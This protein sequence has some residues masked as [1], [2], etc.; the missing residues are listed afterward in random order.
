MSIQTQACTVLDQNWRDGY[1]IPSARL[2]PFQWNWDSGFIALGLAYHRPERAIEEIR[3]MFKGQWRHGLL[4]HINFHKPDSNYFPGPSVWSTHVSPFCPAGI[5]TS[6]ITQPPVFAFIVERIAKLPFGRTPAWRDFEREI[7]PQMLAF[8]RYLYTHRDPEQE[9]LVYIQH[10]WEAGTDN[11]PVW[12]DILDAIDVTGMRDISALRRDVKR[13]DA[14][15][16]P[17][18]ANYQRYIYLVDLFIRAQYRDE[19]IA[20]SSPFLVQDVLFNS[21]LV[22]SNFA[23]LELARRL[24]EPTAEIE[25]WNAKAVGAINRKLWDPVT[26]FYYAYDLRNRRSIRIKTSSGFLPLFAGICSEEQ[27]ARL[28]HHLE[29]TFAP[30]P[31]WRICP[32][33]APDEPRFDPVKYW[34]G[35]V[36]FNLNWML[37]H[38]LRRAGYDALA[39]RLM[40]DAMALTEQSGFYEY[41]DARPAG[42]DGTTEGLGADL[43]S[44]NAALLLD[45]THNPA[46]L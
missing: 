21:L 15:H 24:G 9:G 41:F 17:T 11:S 14:S 33:T 13:V 30:G 19:E 35:P 32:S 4:P 7:Y 12:D 26:G 28:A 18:N 31:G 25:A 36:W 2:Y 38:G 6:G 37:Y 22:K 8:H 16:R 45:F 44:W 20:A 1:T 23:L 27:A 46:L 3:S 29:T 42:A 10:N 43:F 39:G 40:A 34:R 5:A